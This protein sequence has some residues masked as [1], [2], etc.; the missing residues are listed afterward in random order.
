MR[1]AQ[2]LTHCNRPSSSE[3]ESVRNFFN[4]RQPVVPSELQF[5]N[6][7]EDL[8]TLRPGREHAWLDAAIE[9]GL[10]WSKC[11]WIEVSKLL[12]R[13]ANDAN[14]HQVLVQFKGMPTSYISWS[15][16]LT[17]STRIQDRRQTVLRSTSLVSESTCL[18]IQSSSL[19]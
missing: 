18:Q 1:A 3:H 2:S 6:C 16:F 17:R 9:K 14:V 4:R 12:N 10:K 19:W 13:Y 11:D 8:I 5:I 7:K 15:Y